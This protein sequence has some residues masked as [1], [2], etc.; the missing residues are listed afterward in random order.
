MD[1]IGRAVE[2]F[3]L[4]GATLL[5]VPESHSSQVRVA[6]LQDGQRLLL[7]VPSQRY[8]LFRELAALRALRELAPV[9]Q[10]LDWWPGDGATPGALL[11]SHVDGSPL[12]GPVSTQQAA[13]MGRV[14]AG[15]HLAPVTAFGAHDDTGTFAVSAHG[16]WKHLALRF[17][18]WTG[19]AAGHVDPRLLERAGS[20]F[21]LL[22]EQA[23]P[24]GGPCL[25]HNDFRPGNLLV[26]HGGRVVAV[27]DFESSTV[28]AAGADFTKIASY[29]WDRYPGTRQ[30]FVA[31]YTQLCPLPN[32]AD[33]LPLYRLLNAVGGL[34]WCV[35]REQA[36]SEFFGENLSALE[37]LLH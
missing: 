19:Q 14:L 21:G 18:L 20:R 9:P 35:R 8:K 36:G 4:K 27:I 3:G 16:W 34:A 11:L 23:P 2:A 13:E 30:A 32:L 29:V 33:T 24:P 26:D 6:V 10:V 37:S 1:P 5:P 31:G 22:L 15:I 25:L 12:A 17:E 7:K 28:G